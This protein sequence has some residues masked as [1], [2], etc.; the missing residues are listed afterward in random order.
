MNEFFAF[1]SLFIA[2]A[3][4]LLFAYWIDKKRLERMIKRYNKR[5]NAN[6]YTSFKDMKRLHVQYDEWFVAMFVPDKESKMS[7][8]ERVGCLEG[9]ND[10]EK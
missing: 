4:M 9:W 7:Y 8:W 5:F 6:L 1:L 2:L 3:V 10:D